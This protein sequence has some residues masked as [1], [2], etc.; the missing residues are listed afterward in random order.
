MISLRRQ[1]IAKRTDSGMGRQI[2][3]VPVSWTRCTRRCAQAGEGCGKSRRQWPPRLSSRASAAVAIINATSAGSATAP[4]LKASGS[5]RSTAATSPAR[6]RTTPSASLTAARRARASGA[7]GRATGRG[8]PGGAA[9]DAGDAVG[10][11]AGHHHGLEQRIAGQTIGAVQAARRRLAARPQAVDRA[12]ARRVHDDA[13][14]VVV[15][16]RPHGDGLD[17]GIEAGG[18]AACRDGG[19]ARR[20]IAAQRGTRVEEDTMAGG[21]VGGHGARDDVARLELGAPLP[22]HETRA[23]LVD[24]HRAFAAHRLADQRHG[25]E[26]DIE[27]GGME[28]HEFHVGESGAGARRE[29]QALTNGA[30]RIGGMGV[31][32]A[33][34]AGR[35]HHATGGQQAG[36][37]RSCRQHARHAAVV[38]QQA[39]RLQPLDHGDGRRGAHG[40]NQRPHDRRAR[41]VAGDMDDAP[42]RVGGFAGP[43]ANLPCASRSKATPQ[44]SSSAMAA[45]AAAAMRAATAEVAQPVAGGE[46]VRGMQRRR[47]RRRPARRRR[48]PAP[49]P[50]RRPR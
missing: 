40:G 19:E 37:P 38:D 34:P 41:A 17:R 11:P 14:H 20:E 23:G 46:R 12:A 30:Q 44:R 4:P 48:R 2:S 16:R 1:G 9:V 8:A 36:A 45:G 7:G 29:R 31:E 43:C 50:R 49:R 27:R 47:S 6:S 25:I 10:H 33:Q 5:S 28:L 22:R 24:Q 32:P 18:A 26:T 39:A 35:Q 15:D 3:R 21:D 42:A 13:A